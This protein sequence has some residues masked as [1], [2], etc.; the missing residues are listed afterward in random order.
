MIGD[1]AD[2]FEKMA[3]V[4]DRHAARFQ[5]A[6]RREQPINIPVFQTTGGFIH[7]D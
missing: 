1:L 4:N 7:Q 6:N 5:P 3:D 2:L